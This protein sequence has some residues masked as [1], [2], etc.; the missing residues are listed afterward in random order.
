[1]LQ[2]IT[3]SVMMNSLLTPN[4]KEG[5]DHS[6]TGLNSLAVS[7]YSCIEEVIIYFK[8]ALAAVPIYF[9]N[10]NEFLEL[11]PPLWQWRPLKC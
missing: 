5:V 1:M 9:L 7:V 11:L 10:I 3:F 8:N 4:G 2:K 6:A